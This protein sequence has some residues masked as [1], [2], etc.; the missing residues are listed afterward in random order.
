MAKAI[1]GRAYKR[2]KQWWIDFMYKGKRYREAVGP[3][4]ELAQDVLAKRKVEVRENRFFPDKRREP[5]PIKFHEFGK[6][7]LQWARANKKPSSWSRELSTM[8]RLDK[9]FGEKILQEIT[10]WEIEKWKVKRKEAIKRPDANIVSRKKKGRGKNEKEVWCVEFASPRS[11]RG[12]RT[13]ETKDEA[14]AY[15]RKVQTPVRPATLNRELS[16]LKHMYTKAIEWGKCKENPAKKVKKLKGEFKRVRFLLP[17]EVQ[18]LLSNCADYLRP[19]VTVAVHTGMRKGEIFGLRWEQ[20]NFEQGIITLQETKNG[21]RRDIP[22]DETVKATLK[23]IERKGN[24]LFCNEEGDTFV[25]LQRSFEGALRKSGI[26][27]FRFHDLRHTFASNMVMAGEDLNTV[28]ELLGHKDLTMT[29]RYAHLSPSHK[30]RAI[31][32]LD[33]VLS[34]NLPQTEKASKVVSLRP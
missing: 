2:G 31:N 30:T 11:R 32:V 9:E 27:D 26:Q 10:A 33:Q 23:G 25:R 24:Y 3:D 22:M 7:Y 15:L 20:V 28:R 8:R 17:D 16:L 1:K 18:R 14:E 34:Q 19:I 21:E 4:E 6:E 5:D 29:L 12:K 13:F